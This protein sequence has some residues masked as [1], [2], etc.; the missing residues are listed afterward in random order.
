M[1]KQ[2]QTPDIRRNWPQEKLLKFAG[3]KPVFK[4]KKCFEYPWVYSETFKG[5]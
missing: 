5:F 1:L 4:I 3:R 2:P